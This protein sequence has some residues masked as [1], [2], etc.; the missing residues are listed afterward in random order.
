MRTYLDDFQPVKQARTPSRS[1]N[2]LVVSTYSQASQVDLSQAREQVKHFTYW[3]FIAIDRIATKVSECFPNFGRA[4]GTAPISRQRMAWVRQSYRSVLQSYDEDLTEIES[5]PIIDLFR[6]VNP[7]DTW[8]DFIY[9]SILF[10][11]LTGRCYWWIIPNGF[12][13]PAQLWVVPTQLCVCIYTPSGE[14]DHWEVTPEGSGRPLRIEADE[15][16]E[17]KNK[18]PLGK[19][20]ATSP[21]QAGAAFIDNSES[22]EESRFFAFKNKNGADV[23]LELDAETYKGMDPASDILVRIKEKFMAKVSGTRRTGEPIVAPPGIAVKPFGRTPV[24]MGYIESADQTRDQVLALHN[25]PKVIAGI[26]TDVNRATVEGANVIFCQHTINP[27]LRSLAGFISEFLCPRFPGGL[28]AWFDDCVP[29]DAAEEREET[30]LDWQIGAVSPDE[31]REARGRKPLSIKGVSDVG[32]LPSSVVPLAEPVEDET[33]GLNPDG[34]PVVPGTEE[35][36][37]DE[38]DDAED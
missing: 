11:R 10:K 6:D 7:V 5:H 32:Y 9:E 37:D 1:S 36:D 38:P 17:W 4:A 35:I 12:G 18:S 33:A 13:R 25:V 20:Y 8:R 3:N 19:L 14:I 31:R 23:I 24:E 21:T 29:Q 34:T 15:I 26:T 27:E 16:V 30:K 28:V 22:I 2:P